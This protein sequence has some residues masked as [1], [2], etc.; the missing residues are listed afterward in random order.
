VRTYGVAVIYSDAGNEF[1]DMNLEYLQW[2]ARL[3]GM[4][5]GLGLCVRRRD[6]GRAG[7]IPWVTETHENC[8]V[9]EVWNG[10]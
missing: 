7:A 5:R 6:L 3:Q 10:W 1:G 8:R 9:P 4:S 2:F